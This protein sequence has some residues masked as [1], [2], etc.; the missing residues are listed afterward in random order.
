MQRH[1]VVEPPFPRY[2]VI[3]GKP[4]RDLPQPSFSSLCVHL[5]LQQ[6]LTEQGYVAFRSLQ[7]RPIL[8]PPQPV[9]HQTAS[10]TRTWRTG[11]SPS[12][13]PA[14]PASH[15]S[16]PAAAGNRE[17]LN[18]RQ[19]AQD[20]SSLYS[21]CRGDQSNSPPQEWCGVL[22][23]CIGTGCPIRLRGVLSNRRASVQL[24]QGEFKRQMRHRVGAAD[25]AWRYQAGSCGTNSVT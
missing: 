16:S 8:S 20:H 21:R 23:V 9:P 18:P 13:P 2:S 12:D 24:S 5:H 4:L 1:S 25:W 11:Q 3:N 10:A 7:P 17:S 19:R 15:H 14:R 6:I 22:R